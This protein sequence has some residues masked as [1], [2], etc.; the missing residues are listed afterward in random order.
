[1]TIRL[2]LL[3]VCTAVLLTA[4]LSFALPPT[5][6]EAAITATDINSIDNTT[7]IDANAILMFVTNH[8]NF[9]RDLADV[10]GNDYGTYY[11]YTGT[12]NIYNGSNTRSPL[13]AA[14][15]WLGGKVNGDIRV[16][17]SEYS[18]EYA[19]GPMYGG[20][21]QADN[22]DFKVYKLYRDSLADN[23]NNDYL[24]WPQDQGAPVDALG[25]P[26]MIGEQMLW[27]VFNDASPSQHT[28]DAGET[29]PL[30]VEV[31]M[32]TWEVTG[33]TL[34]TI[35][36]DVSETAAHTGPSHGVVEI[37]SVGQPVYPSDHY[38]V[39]FTD[40]FLVD[41]EDTVHSL[42]NLDNITRDQRLLSNQ[43]EP[44]GDDDPSIVQGFK[45]NV[46]PLPTGIAAIEEIAT[47]TGAITPPDDVAYSLNSSGDWYVS[48]DAGSDFSRMNWR[49][50][51]GASDWEIRFTATGSEYYN[52]SGDGK[53]A[54]RAPFEV[55]NIGEGTPDDTTDDR[56]IFF[57]ILDDDAS[58]GWSWGDRIYPWE[59]E[60]FEPAPDN[61]ATLYVFD[62]D[63][64]IGRI[65]FRDF[66]GALSAPAE[67]TVVRFATYKDFYNTSA[68]TFSFTPPVPDWYTISDGQQSTVVYLQYELFNKGGNQIDSMFVSIWA[69]PD[70]GGAG[71]DF[72]GCDSILDIIYAYNADNNDE[73]YG[74]SPP[75]AGFR[76]LYGPR[77][78]GSIADTAFY[79][80]Q[81]Y[82]GFDNLGMTATNK[83][84]NG[85][86]P[87]NHI[88]TFRYMKGLYADGSP[89]TYN[90]Q[91]TTYVH[92]G[93]PLTGTGDLDIAP[94]DRRMM[95]SMG[96]ITMMPGDSQYVLV[97]FAVGQGTDRL[98]SISQMYNVMSAFPNIPTD[99]GDNHP[100]AAL[101]GDFSLAQNYPNPFNPTTT[102]SYSLPR[103]SE[104]ELIV[105][106]VLGQ[107]VVT[108]VDE[109]K[110]AGTWNVV[111]DGS[112]SH[113][114]KVASGVYF[115]RLVT[116]GQTQ[117]RKMILLK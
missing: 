34:D 27:T 22:P 42:W 104:V 12:A 74:A 105:L 10:F 117:S 23:P 107:K 115:Y 96:P 59:V 56:R 50:R 36:I 43:R 68:D 28:N 1:M 45:I 20:T 106:N 7:Y 31:R 29:D 78:P 48:S 109:T 51:V 79:F 47:D 9:G 21:Y 93:N 2:H 33:T 87:N 24:N 25:N 60:Y 66:S 82:P 55:W 108:L 69:D 52:W 111:W 77:V 30:G 38:E 3:T 76:V 67:G 39:T 75:A 83:Y 44:W 90:M 102:I 61:A 113:G 26:L 37:W 65:I 35:Y 99:I 112:N 62:E 63:F 46:V 32:T 57:S 53:F 16:A 18:S 49:G 110:P 41:G 15:L 19:P 5:D 8:G 85:L 80:G 72:Y 92:S 114:E 64:R 95:G 14:G 100:E 40:T 86:D 6:R 54:D 98:S 89:Y 70:I 13:Y 17:I 91:P 94:A 4:T 84:I 88:E 103:Q 101:P 11:P 73:Q 71:D 81:F 97:M 116:D 58:G